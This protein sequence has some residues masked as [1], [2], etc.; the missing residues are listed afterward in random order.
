MVESL[1]KQSGMSRV[2]TLTITEPPEAS[3]A[4]AANASTA[5]A[6]ADSTGTVTKPTLVALNVTLTVAGNFSNLPLLLDLL[7]KNLRLFEIQTLTAEESGK[8][9]AQTFNLTFNTYYQK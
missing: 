1:A 2:M 8:G 7:E 6:P 5:P 4:P 9:E 3:G